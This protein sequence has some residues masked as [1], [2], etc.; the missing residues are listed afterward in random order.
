MADLTPAQELREAAKLM[1][2]RASEAERPGYESSHPG[3]PWC[4][5]W[6]YSV[7]RHVS[8]NLD[9][10]CS[11]HPWGSEHEGDCNQWGRWAG[12]HI[13]AMHPG[14]A[15]A[16]ADWLEAAA[17]DADEFL[18]LDAPE[19]GHADAPCRC[20][21]TPVWGCDRCGEYLSPGACTCWNA[22]LAVARAYLN[23]E[24]TQ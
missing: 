19:C 23:S 12:Y 11:E 14:V 3:R 7:V 4:P 10:E 13:A 9:T 20:D 17:S 5:A 21:H 16:V 15:L 22:A 6:T 18:E 1:R 2:E 24:G 8:R